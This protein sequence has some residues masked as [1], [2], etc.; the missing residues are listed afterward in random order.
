MGTIDQDRC[1]VQRPRTATGEGRT[2]ENRRPVTTSGEAARSVRLSSCDDHTPKAFRWSMWGRISTVRLHWLH[3]S[4]SNTDT[5]TSGNSIN[6]MASSWRG[7]STVVCDERQEVDHFA[8]HRVSAG[9]GGHAPATP[10]SR[11][12]Q[13]AWSTG[14][15]GWYSKEGLQC[16]LA[17]NVCVEGRVHLRFAA[18]R[19]F[20]MPVVSSIPA[21][22]MKRSSVLSPYL[23]TPVTRRAV[24]AGAALLTTL[25]SRG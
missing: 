21:C 18:S 1:G 5:P 6:A 9:N 10:E 4:S 12:L 15:D 22:S 14:I 3:V 7:N 11:A 2:G 8:A 20:T 17:E 13:K 16:A 24:P 23:G 19:L 25:R